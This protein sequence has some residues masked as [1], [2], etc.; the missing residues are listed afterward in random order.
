[1]G[2]QQLED[3]SAF[4]MQTCMLGLMNWVWGLTL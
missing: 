3:F 1:M 2:V 4:C